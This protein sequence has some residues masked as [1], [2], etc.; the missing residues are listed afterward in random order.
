MKVKSKKLSDTRVEIKVT[1]DKNDLAIA[2]EKAIDR[3]TK[4]LNLRV[5]EKGK[6]RAN[7]P[8]KP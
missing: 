2:K 1:L 6:L 3:L 4:K 7:S 8:R 5:S